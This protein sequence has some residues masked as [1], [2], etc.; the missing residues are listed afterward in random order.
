MEPITKKC[1]MK[2]E[3][4][5]KSRKLK[6][7][8][9]SLNNTNEIF[10]NIQNNLNLLN[11]SLVDAQLFTDSCNSKFQKFRL[12]LNYKNTKSKFE[13]A[14][15]DSDKE[16]NIEPIATKCRKKKEIKKKSRKLKEKSF[17]LNNT[18]EILGNIQNKL[19]LLNPNII[20]AQLFT[21]SCNS[22]EYS[23]YFAQRLITDK[24]RFAN[25]TQGIQIKC[26]KQNKILNSS[27][28]QPLSINN[29]SVRIVK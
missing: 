24:T 3:I 9:S 13:Q 4:K 7:K 16:N 25:P 6:E 27:A 1:R 29:F 28:S 22:Q 12:P 19:S 11:P 14:I 21:D 20:D 5:K 26:G 2:K 10:G 17:S 23:D 18:N 8:S 15:I